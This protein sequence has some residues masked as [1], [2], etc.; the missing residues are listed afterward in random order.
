MGGFM[1]YVDNEPW[2]TLTPDELRD[3]VEKGSVDM[4]DMK[5]TDIEDRS[6]GDV[7][8]KGIALFQLAWFILQLLIRL[9]QRLPITLLEVDTFAVVILTCIAYGLWWKKPKDVGHPYPVH[10]KPAAPPQSLHYAYVVNII[11]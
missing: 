2:A 8:S 4:P 3:F 1:L 11:V 5:K 6:R 7:L 10:W 9:V